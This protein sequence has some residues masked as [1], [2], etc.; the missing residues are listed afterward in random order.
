MSKAWPKVRLGEVLRR[1]ERFEPRDEL[2]EY[3]FAGTYSFARGIFVGQRKSGSSFALPKIQRIHSGDFV[4]CK[5]MAW[6]GAFGLVPPEADGCVLSGAFVAYTLN[7]DRFD[8]RFLDYFFRVPT[9]WKEIG[10]QSSGTNVRRQSL[11]PSQFESA[12]I[13]LPPLPQQ[14]A[15]VVRIEELAGQIQE[16]RDLRR[17]AAKETV[18]LVASARSSLFR[19]SPGDPTLADVCKDVTDGTHDTPQYVDHGYPFLTGKDISPDGLNFDGVRHIGKDDYERF[20]KHC[21]VERGDVLLTLIG[22]IDK[23]AIVDTDRSFSIKNV[24]LLKPNPELMDARYLFAFLQSSAFQKQAISYAKKTAQ[25][26]V[27]LKKL[28]TA[29]IP[30]PPLAQQQQIVLELDALQAEA[31]TLN[32][33]QAKTSAELDA[34]LPA[35]LDRAFKGELA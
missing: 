23:V 5:I 21:P 30:I 17:E 35:I 3:P 14:R 7:R 12:E 1:V 34:L 4:Y 28:R 13:P 18:A 26:F 9:H 15:I 10:S 19:I 11:H 31:R 20:A 33:L 24:G 32:H 25:A 29:R 2:T 16:A 27:G 22:T 8:P 6:E